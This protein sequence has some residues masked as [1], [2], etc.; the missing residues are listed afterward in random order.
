[1]IFPKTELRVGDFLKDL[2]EVQREAVQEYKG[3]GLIIAGAGSGKTRVLI[4]RIAWILRQGI[5]ASS[6]LAL[7]FT[8]KA[9]SEMKE[10]ISSL[11]GAEISKYLWMG[12][13]HSIFARILRF[14]SEHT[15]YT[16]NFTIYDSQDSKSVIKTISR[17]LMLDEQIYK[18][19][20]VFGRISSAKNN[21]IGAGAYAVNTGIIAED[22]RNRKPRIADIFRIYQARCRA[23]DAMDFDDLLLNTNILFR[24]VPEVLAKY[25]DMFKYILVDEYQDTNYAQYLIVSKLAHKHGNISVVGDDAQSIYSFRGARIEN[26]L[27]FK[28]DYPGHKT[29]KLEQNYRSTK[30]IVN[31]ANSLIARNKGQIPKKV[32]SAKETGEKLMVLQ[33]AT[34]HEEG[35]VIAGLIADKKISTRC[36]YAD[37]AVLYR[38]N[39]QSRIFEEA[40]RFRS[41]PYKVYG[42]LS[43]YQR[44]EIKDLLAYFRLTVNNRDQEAFNRI[45]N[46]PARGIGN[47][48]TGKLTAWS[49]SQGVSC[50]DIISNIEQYQ[51]AL[52]INKG[53][54]GKLTSFSRLMQGFSQKAEDADAWSLAI[55]IATASGILKDLFDPNSAEN[56]AK[57]ENIQELLNAVKEF[58]RQ[59]EEAGE[60]A[61]LTAFL[62]T[63][64]LLSDADTEKPDDR[65]KVTLMTIHSAKGLEFDHIFIGGLEE[66]LFPNKFSAASE[67]ELEEERRLFYV[68][69]TRAASTATISYAQSRYRWGVPTLCRPSRF[70]S[71][72]DTQFIEIPGPGLHGNDINDHIVNGKGQGFSER[73]NKPYTGNSGNSGKSF[74][75]TLPDKPAQTVQPLLHRKKLTRID[76]AIE[77]KDA[78]LPRYG[79]EERT[80][81]TENQSSLKPGMVVEH[82]RFGR[83]RITA[84]EG[85]SPNTKATVLFATAGQKHLLLKFARLRIINS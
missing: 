61:S 20:E 82:E 48:T 79:S 50:W 84:I 23:A 35:K 18:P 16:S 37:F 9:A 32:W 38:T 73:Q 40:L 68:A 60:N 52:D 41:I 15:G 81:A 19:G 42:S 44:K 34:D 66:E 4:Y 53:A 10:R 46:Y 64:S 69:I 70:I 3:P 56:I 24:D 62:Q 57:Y 65:D 49:N 80:P 27:N 28:N 78:S 72:I 31:A 45:I 59:Q 63:V 7:T 33:C 17:E 58:T 26:I 30:N 11:V 2:N 29:F 85:E 12:T 6:I 8:N 55:H 13:F 47:T 51:S 75:K 77:N 22:A 5:P 36:D 67:T 71:E 21:L 25:Q 74:H 14:E 76:R 43:F 83:G 1:M 54:A 39:A